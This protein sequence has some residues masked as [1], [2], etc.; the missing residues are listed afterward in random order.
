MVRLQAT[1][2]PDVQATIEDS[3]VGHL[4]T[5]VFNGQVLAPA[6]QEAIDAEQ[7][8]VETHILRLPTGQYITPA[9]FDYYSH[10]TRTFQ[11]C[12]QLAE[13]FPHRLT[14]AEASN[15]TRGLWEDWWKDCKSLIE[16]IQRL[17]FDNEQTAVI[18]ELDLKLGE[19]FGFFER[20]RQ[21]EALEAQVKSKTR[22]GRQC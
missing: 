19:T 11:F 18:N 9:N 6:N 7:T 8:E 2:L 10:R 21:I 12:E 13:K 17:P 15:T 22:S 5:S 16:V 14:W 1:I 20:R 4:Q 3:P